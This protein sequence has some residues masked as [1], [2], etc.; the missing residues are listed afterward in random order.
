MRQRRSGRAVLVLHHARDQ[1]RQTLPSGVDAIARGLVA[2][3]VKKLLIV[4]GGAN[5]TGDACEAWHWHG[6]V[7][8]EAEA[9]RLITG[10][11]DRPVP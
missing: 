3:P 4:D 2:A 10:W 8:M 11:M 6:F 7:G 9:V 5:P 1:C